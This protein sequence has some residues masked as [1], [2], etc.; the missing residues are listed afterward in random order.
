MDVSPG[1]EQYAL[2]ARFPNGV[3]AMSDA[4]MTD[5]M[6]YVYMQYPQPA[7]MVGVDVTITVVD[8]NGNTPTVATAT[9]DANGGFCCE[10]VPEVTGMYTVIA[11][12][13]GS[14]AY[15]GSSSAT[16][17]KVNDAVATPAPSETPGTMT[18]AYVLGLGAASIAAIVAIG[19]I[20]ILMLRKR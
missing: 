13:E 15:C 3:P 19:L 2:R 9:S 11:T 20:I 6:Q 18:D 1:T 5:W 7:D 10:F 16:Y 4:N 14:G 17:L 8:P 12:F